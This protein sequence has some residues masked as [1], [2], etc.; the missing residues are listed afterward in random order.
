MVA[1]AEIWFRIYGVDAHN[2]HKPPNPL[3]F[4]AD[5]YTMK[6]AGDAAITPSRS[7]GVNFIDPVHDGEFMFIG[8]CH[9]SLA[10]D[11]NSIDIA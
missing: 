1:L 11:A 5:F 2:P 4:N 6:N 9:R 7:G 8:N 3:M 10:V